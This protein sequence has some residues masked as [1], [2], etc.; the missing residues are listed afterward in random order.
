MNTTSMGMGIDGMNQASALVSSLLCHVNRSSQKAMTIC[1]H[2]MLA[3]RDGTRSASSVPF[4]F[5]KNINSPLESVAP[6]I[7]SG[8]RPRS[9][10][11]GLLSSSVFLL[12]GFLAESSS[13]L[14][15][16]FLFFLSVVGAASFFCFS[17]NSKNYKSCK[18]IP[19]MNKQNRWVSP[20]PG[21]QTFSVT[22]IES[23]KGFLSALTHH[24]ISCVFFYNLWMKENPFFYDQI[25]LMKLHISSNKL[26]LVLHKILTAFL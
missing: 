1:G 10:P 13:N 21:S 2:L 18:S 23:P 19:I 25:D 8:S 12:L 7:L 6:I 4:H 14:E 17:S 11:F 5:I 20:D 15:S 9:K 3:C 22:A 26:R 24:Y 16:F